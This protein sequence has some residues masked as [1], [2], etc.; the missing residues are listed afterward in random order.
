MDLEAE[1]L[2]SSD[3]THRSPRV[4]LADRK[5]GLASG[6]DSEPKSEANF[7]HGGHKRRET[8][9]PREARDCDPQGC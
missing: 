8:V 6:T 2:E 9:T 4:H 1:G 3:D 5:R 7:R